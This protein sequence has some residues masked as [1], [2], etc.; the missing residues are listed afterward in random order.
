M[1]IQDKSKIKVI[2]VEIPSK[3]DR[4][5][6]CEGTVGQLCFFT[7]MH[8]GV[9]RF[10]GVSCGFLSSNELIVKICGRFQSL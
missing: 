5:A 3:F 6:V 1:C 2:R 9:S 4:K 10:S 7:G 8:D